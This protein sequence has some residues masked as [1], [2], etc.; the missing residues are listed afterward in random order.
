VSDRN[1]PTFIGQNGEPVTFIEQDQDIDHAHRILNWVTTGIW[2]KYARGIAEHGGHLPHKG[3]LLKEA[4]CEVLDLIV[5]VSTIREQMTRI[6]G[7]LEA[8]RVE[9][10]RLGLRHLLHGTTADRMPT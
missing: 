7:Q 5:Y 10:A 4:E 2:N 8:G 1:Q 9:D 3:G 6:E